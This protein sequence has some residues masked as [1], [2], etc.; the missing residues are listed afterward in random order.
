MTPRR[1]PPG[2]MNPRRR[3]G[4]A[5]LHLA[6]LRSAAWLVPGPQRAEWFAEWRAELWYVKQ[7]PAV[8]CL[9]A[10]R[11]AFWLRR[12]SPTP[13]ARHTFG[14]ESPARCILL[15][16]VLAAASLFFAFRLPFVRDILLPSPY[17]DARNLAM[18]SAG[19]RFG[20]Q[21][22]TIPIEQY[23]SL[24]NRAQHLFTDLA[25]YRTMQT[26]VRTAP[27]KSAE[28]SIA[29]ASENLFQWLQ[30]PVSSPAPNPGGRRPATWLVLSRA[31]WRKYFDA[32]PRIVG[33][34]LEVAGQPAVVA[35]VIP[36][37][38]WCLPGRMDA[39]LLQD[40]AHLAELPPHTKGF[41]LGHLRTSP[42]QAQPDLRWRI[43]VPN[44]QGGSDR[45]ECWSLAKG[46]IVLAYLLITLLCLLI[47][48]ANIP[49]ALGEYPANLHSPRGV[50]R[51]RRWIFLVIKI[52]LLLVIV[53]CGS[54]DLASIVSVDLYPT[55][56]LVG[57]ILGLRWALIDQR[58]RCPVCL[59]L[60]GNPTRIGGP[61]RTLLEWYGTEL[62][63]AQGHG[64]LYVPEIP[65]SCYSTQR[66]QYLD[67]SWSSLF[68]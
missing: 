48:S 65:T 36:G 57:L 22:P 68:S 31:A 30:I 56:W 6:I 45:F 37:S 38:S 46:D 58:Q 40:Q 28:L 18:I 11:D 4:S 62:I 8:F 53:G 1:M 15:L 42:W 63:C 26:R 14:L 13:N 52:V 61:S 7:S 21:V 35:G 55:G 33:R 29:V 12:N 50:M 25:F 17:P 51:L 60:L 20:P 64:L 10:F 16:A 32:D 66:W 5:P 3:L 49:L 2:R 34:V 47:L 43:S 24:A 9:G 44:E 54:F 67:P 19:G 59:R 39:W 23:R 27:R 41:V